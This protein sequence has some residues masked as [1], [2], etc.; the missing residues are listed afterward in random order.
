MRFIIIP[1]LNDRDDH[2]INIGKIV[3]KLKNLLEINVMPYH[4]YGVDKGQKAGMNLQK[5]DYEVPDDEKVA[6]WIETLQQFTGVP[7]RRG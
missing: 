1:G 3:G 4:N 5:L 2:F 7:V 6:L